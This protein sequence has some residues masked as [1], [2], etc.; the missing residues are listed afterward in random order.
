RESRPRNPTSTAI[1]GPAT[2]RSAA[3]LT[4]SL[5]AMPD[6][7]AG[8]LRRAT[9]V[10]LLAALI[11]GAMIPVLAELA[12][13]FDKWLLSWMRYLLGMPVLW[14]AVLVWRRPASPTPRPL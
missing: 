11:W 5:Q 3:A 6:S 8:A 9:L 1:A 14:L 10:L 2:R 7:S 12:Q 13:H 4:F